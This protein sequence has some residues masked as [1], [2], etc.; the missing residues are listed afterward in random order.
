MKK[1]AGISMLLIDMTTPGVEVRPIE[2]IDG[3]HEVNEVWFTDVRVPGENLVGEVNERLDDGQVP[4]R[5]R[6][7]RRRARSG[8]VKR[9]LAALKELA[10][11]RC[12]TTP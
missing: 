1:Q 10:G 9:S 11:T 12:S 5:Q 8:A 6:A 7:G 3:G 4:A 2:L